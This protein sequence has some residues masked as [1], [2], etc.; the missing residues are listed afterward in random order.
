MKNEKTKRMVTLSILIALIIVLQ[1][2]GGLIPTIGG[3]SIS[4]VLLPIVLGAVLLGPGSGAVLGAAF[5]VIAYINCVMGTDKMG[6]AV[7]S[8]NPWLCFVLVMAKGTFAG[9]SSGIVYRLFKNKKP[10]AANLCAAIVCPVVNTGIFIGGMLLCFEDV[11][12]AFSIEAKRPDIWSFILAIIILANFL[13]ELIINV[14]LSPINQ[15]VVQVV[16]K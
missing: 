14:A 11:L 10:Y 7:F 2:I 13:P 15:R 8:A 4:L 6:N 9:L 12:Q 3:F 16:N 1:Y 5:G